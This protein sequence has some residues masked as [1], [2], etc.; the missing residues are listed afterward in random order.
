VSAIVAAVITGILTGIG[1]AWVA[2]YQAQVQQQWNRKEQAYREILEALVTLL[3]ETAHRA[4]AREQHADFPRP[5]D[6]VIANEAKAANAVL[7]KYATIG[8][9]VVSQDA[10]NIL[11]SFRRK[12]IEAWN[13]NLEDEE[14]SGIIN[15]TVKSVKAAAQV[16]L[17]SVSRAPWLPTNFPRLRAG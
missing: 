15:A 14:W 17:K 7:N 5:E 8:S 4:M 12:M 3:R 2:L 13:D 6:E 9:F 10:E 11:A 16:D 1:S